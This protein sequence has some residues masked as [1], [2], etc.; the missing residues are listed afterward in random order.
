MVC[1]PPKGEGAGAAAPPPNGEG[2]VAAAGA[3]APPKGDGEGAFA[4]VEPKVGIGAIALLV[5]PNREDPPLGPV[6]AAG[7]FGP[8]CMSAGSGLGALSGK[9]W[10]KEGG[11]EVVRGTVC[12]HKVASTDMDNTSNR[13]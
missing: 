7:G 4:G 8:P 2:D 3:G 5:P 12:G 9:E 13:H 10:W 1:P 6:G 11:Q